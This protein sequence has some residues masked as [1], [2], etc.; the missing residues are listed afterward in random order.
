MN[1]I[2]KFHSDS[3]INALKAFFEELKVP[4]NYLADEPAYA[5]DVLGERFKATNEAHQLIDD[6]YALGMV[7]DAIFEGTETFKNLAEV[8]QLKADYDGLL[9]FGVTLKSRKDGLP[10]TRSH[11]A[12]IT[13]AFNR[14]FPYT[15]V[16]I[17]FKY[18]NLISFANSERIKYKQEWRE[19][20]KIGKVT[21]LKDVN[22]QNP[23]AAH[24]KI[25]FGLTIDRLKI[26]SFKF[27]Y[28][29]WQSVFSL[30]ALNN[31]FYADLQDWFYYASQNIKLPYKPDYINDKENIKNF[32][33][34]LLARTMFCWF[35]KEKGL[36]K[37]EL[38]EL[39]DWNGNRFKLTNDVEDKK[40]LK[41]NSY[42]RGILQNI[43]FH[44]LNQ[45]EKKTAK[46]FNWSK[47]WHP[48]LKM[49]WL[50]QIPYLNGGIFDKLEE[51]NAKESIEDIAIQIPNFLF[52]GIE[53][54]QEVT[55]GKGARA[56]TKIEKVEQKGLNGILK[57]YKFT[58][59]ENT[60]FEEDIALD[61]EMLGL[62]FE[63]LLAELDPNLEESTIKSIR[64]QTGS[65]Y[66]P[67]KVIFEM[68]NDSLNLYLSR[69][70]SENY[71]NITNAKTKVND[72]VNYTILNE[73]DVVFEQAVV[74]A[75]DKYKVLDPACGSGA[76]P[77]GMLHRIVDILKLVDDN[78]EK[79]VELK[80][81]NIDKAQKAE[82]KKVLTS[83][84]DDYGRKLGIIRDCIYGIDI[85]PLAVQITK[86]RFFISLLI[87]QKTEKG[88][89][90][91]PNI[92]TKIICADSLKNIQSDLYSSKAI[93]SLIEYRTRYYQPD[94]S[95]KERQIIADEIIN[96]LDEAFPSFSFQITNKRIAG[97]NKELIRHWFTHGTIA[98]PFFNMDF[99][100]PELTGTGGFDCVIG[101][102]PYGG[103]KI[104]EELKNALD[105]ESKDPYGAFIARF[106]NAHNKSTPLKH[107]G[108]LAYI[109]SDTFMTIK[110]HFKLR[111]HL[112]QN[113]V[114]KMLRVHPDTFRA[115][116]NTV[117]MIAER[118]TEREL[119]E[120][121]ICLMADL[122]NISIHDNYDH[123]VEVLNQTKG[124]DFL[125]PKANI[126]NE[127]YAIFYYSQAIIKTNRYL[128]FFVASPKLF[129]LMNDCGR[130]LKKEIK[131]IGNKQFQVR[132]ITLNEKEIEVVKLGDIADVKQGLAT[133]DNKAY[134]FQ[135]PEARGTYR[136]IIN[137]QEFLLTKEDL[138]KIRNNHKLRKEVIEKGF[139]KDNLNCDRYFG[140]KYIIPYD[141]GGESD[142]EGGWMPCYYVETNYFIDWSEWSVNRMKTYKIAERIREYGEK[143]V[144]KPSDETTN[145]A[146]IRSPDSYF[147]TA[148]D[149][150]RVGAYSPTYR[151]GTDTVFDSGCNDIY[152]SINSREQNLAIL[153]SRFWRF[154]FIT[155]IN[156]TV[157]SQTDDNDE[158]NYVLNSNEK[159]LIN[160]VNEIIKKQ[161]I[162]PRYDFASHEQ[163]EIDRL[164]YDAYGLNDLDVQ[165]V[166]YWYSRRYPKLSEAQ[167]TNLRNLG[168]SDDYLV[169]YGF[170]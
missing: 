96:V 129:A 132:K 16:T 65:Y 146:I 105:I 103:T 45:K 159:L 148:I 138:E 111:K 134:L 108:V 42:Y 18:G 110:S 137:Y 6:V 76:F 136:S 17:I 112:M 49:D 125:K 168:K 162:I 95:Q 143:K 40:F 121:H 27:L 13:R 153:N 11:L 36:I 47:Y 10:I 90:P 141:K 145:C 30:Q 170:K 91:M 64:K 55:K 89:T 102:P 77:M 154:Q 85:Q 2:S 144:I 142:A 34:R 124:V 24:K 1:S 56:S 87:D 70:I 39:T 75:L 83:H 131:E 20:E 33:V 114:H 106:L 60:P 98:A 71:P 135:K 72:L 26:D 133:G 53:E 152:I 86:L 57:S 84:L 115:T 3:F 118:N 80:L 123:F 100:Y 59:D 25:L 41:N 97:Q 94:I 44:A 12:E 82:F 109:V 166:E 35:V 160:Y 78:N 122:T 93:E 140:G 54:E 31:Q 119:N 164:V 62:V 151:I 63:N 9:L 157:N 158:V 21:M 156:H 120:F 161:N 46:D 48:E 163:I 167:K 79:W 28:N 52:Y 5:L 73:K 66:T 92:E 15:P 61:P 8:Q 4:V 69:Y 58:L 116:V 32:L 139:S 101:N 68:V 150:S 149:C 99:F 51:D 22:C 107:G 117:I 88:I 127:E 113:Y 14:T 37:K 50:T 19:G 7:N 155:F 104:S 38:L 126:S 128:P 29:Y 43:F 165:E 147:T 169:L 67:R 74:D 130:D 81:N 23:H